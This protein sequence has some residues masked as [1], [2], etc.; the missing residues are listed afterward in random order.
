GGT[1][2]YPVSPIVLGEFSMTVAAEAREVVHFALNPVRE[3]LLRPVRLLARY[4]PEHLRG[5]LM[6]GLTVGVLLLPQA[7]AFAL[8][9]E[10]PP[11]MGLYS[12]I[13]GGIVAALWGSSNHT[14]TGPAN[15]ISLLVLSSLQVSFVPG[16]PEFIVAAGLLAVMAG[17]FQLA[18]GL[19]R[20]GMLVN[21]VSHS[22]IV[23]FASG[24]GLLIAIQQLGPLLG[25]GLRNRSLAGMVQELALRLPESH[26]TTA[27][28]GASVIVIMLLLRWVN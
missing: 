13:I 1:P 23:G 17:V 19:L 27:A 11:E 12:A 20:L 26:L 2:P 7:I 4:R 3:Y 18:L 14:H 8:I 6:A 22:V 5:D 10:L 15:A 25:L 21:F 9:A 16:S 28:I 24:A